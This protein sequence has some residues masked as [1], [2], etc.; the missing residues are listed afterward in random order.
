MKYPSSRAVSYQN[1]L[2]QKPQL[3]N[4]SRSESHDRVQKNLRPNLTWRLVL[5]SVTSLIQVPRSCQIQEVQR[6]YHGA[7]WQKA[8][9][10]S[11]LAP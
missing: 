3:S 6:R 9:L 11:L 7:V 2:N 10:M 4:W 1:S 8:S 5:K